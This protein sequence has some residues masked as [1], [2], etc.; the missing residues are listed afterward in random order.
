MLHETLFAL[1]I[2]YEII[3][4]FATWI[5]LGP[6]GS[7][8]FYYCIFCTS[9]LSRLLYCFSHGKNNQIEA[10]CHFTVTEKWKFCSTKQYSYPLMTRENFLEWAHVIWWHLKIYI[11]KNMCTHM[12]W[13]QSNAY[14]QN[15]QLSRPQS[16]TLMSQVFKQSNCS[17]LHS[18]YPSIEIIWR[19]PPKYWAYKRLIGS[20]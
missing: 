10:P 7:S 15:S 11:G 4:W 9:R 3:P 16:L 6:S 18:P 5:K 2:S 8:L 19:S 13:C 12:Q 14:K 20:P 17:K 1:T